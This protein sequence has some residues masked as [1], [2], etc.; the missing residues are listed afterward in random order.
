MK[1]KSLSL[2]LAVI[3][4]PFMLLL[5]SS[6]DKKEDNND[7]R[8]L[9]IRQ[10]ESETIWGNFLSKDTLNF[11][12]NS[13]NQLVYLVSN[14]PENFTEI[15]YNQDGTISQIRDEGP[16][17][18]TVVN[19]EWS[20]N[21]VTTFGWLYVD[22]KNVYELNI[23]GKIKRL[24]IYHH[25]SQDWLMYSYVIFNWLDG[26]LISTET[27]KAK[28]E[29]HIGQKT[30][31]IKSSSVQ[32]TYDKFINPYMMYPL[33]AFDV[34]GWEINSKNNLLSKTYFKF[35]D[36]GFPQMDMEEYSYTYNNLNYPLSKI[37]EDPLQSVKVFFQ[38]E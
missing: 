10:T 38:Y 26:N 35:E 13:K 2:I 21:M 6:C 22:Y 34:K 11:K 1:I 27:W 19:Y 20:G 3:I 28:T 29:L 4:L 18:E 12:Y 23:E 37:K 24:V 31:F 8:T 15:Q 25:N 14:D 7:K 5:V 9:R 36:D 30:E 17:Y 32:Y 16:T 33:F